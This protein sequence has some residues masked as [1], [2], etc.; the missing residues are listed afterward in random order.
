MNL[1]QGYEKLR[2]KN[3]YET[4]N[5]ILKSDIKKSLR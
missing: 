4:E 3:V 1:S 5:P 2:L